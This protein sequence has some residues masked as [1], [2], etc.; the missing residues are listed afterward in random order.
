MNMK[1]M[2][3]EA[4]TYYR[5]RMC[6][7]VEIRNGKTILFI[8]EDEYIYPV[9][10]LFILEPKDFFAHEQGLEEWVDL[11]G[12][13]DILKDINP[14]M[15]LTIHQIHVLKTPDEIDSFE[16]YLERSINRTYL[17]LHTYDKSDIVINWY[18]IMKRARKSSRNAE[19]FFETV[20]YQFYVTLIHELGHA[21]LRDN[22][23]DESFRPLI[24]DEDA[25]LEGDFDEEDMV[26][27][28]ANQIFDQLEDN[29]YVF[30]PFNRALIMAQF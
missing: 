9:N 1:M 29:Y 21:S 24:E 4:M 8:D 30:S 16:S 25:W 14:L 12:L 15:F 19:R 13:S 11:E 18:E 26:E 28:Y 3:N 20:V 22:G 10:D 5:E 23:L 7:E 6:E 17:G 27:D 2:I